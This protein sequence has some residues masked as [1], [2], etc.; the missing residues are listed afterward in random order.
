MT[1]RDQ[2]H[3]WFVY[4]L[5]LVPVWLLD[6]FVLNRVPLFG[7]VPM[8]LPLTV[9]AVAVLEGS[10]AGAGF[11]MAVGLLWELAYP[12]GSGILVFGMTLAGMLTGS[13]AQYALSQSFVSCLLCSAGVLAM[14]D[15]RYLFV[16]AET[17]DVLLQVVAS[18]IAVSLC[19]TPFIYLLF[20][21]VFRR[22]GGTKLA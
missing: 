17:L 10:V 8:L 2:I 11:G 14:I 16:Q 18:E 9:V 1:R 6:E 12:G 3:K 22:V 7:V 20:R 15:V 4:A 5:A 19:F 21:M 13:I